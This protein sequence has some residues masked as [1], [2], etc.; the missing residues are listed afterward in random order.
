MI[1]SIIVFHVHMYISFVYIRLHH[2]CRYLEA[3]KCFPSVVTVCLHV[4]SKH[5]FSIS[6]M[7]R[8]SG[9][10][11]IFVGTNVGRSYYYGQL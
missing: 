11:F 10:S 5:N 6:G 9:T 7:A 8:S 2:K 3:A 1:S 4:I